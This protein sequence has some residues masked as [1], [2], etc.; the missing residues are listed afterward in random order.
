MNK[1]SKCIHFFVTFFLIFH[2]ENSL[3][4]TLE[5]YKDQVNECAVIQY[6]DRDDQVV[7]QKC[8][9]FDST[10]SPFYKI[11]LFVIKVNVPFDLFMKN[12]A[13]VV[14]EDGSK[15]KIKDK[16]SLLYKGNDS[17]QLS[18]AHQLDSSEFELLCTKQISYFKIN[19]YAKEFDKSQGAYIIKVLQKL[20]NEKSF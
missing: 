12:W 10:Q 18:V 11:G 16:I 4:Q 9:P 8:F 19:D 6:Y 3:A 14:F 5:R 17:N 15:I 1:Y 20:K 13:I 7:I 2:I